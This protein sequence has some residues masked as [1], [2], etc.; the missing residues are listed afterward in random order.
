MAFDVVAWSH[1]IAYRHVCVTCML[2]PFIRRLTRH[3][4][5]SPAGFCRRRANWPRRQ[6][7]SDWPRLARRICRR[8]PTRISHSTGFTI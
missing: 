4:T 6:S 7:F 1:V 8:E 3:G 2:D 5:T